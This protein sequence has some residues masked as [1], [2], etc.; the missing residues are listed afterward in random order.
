[1]GQDHKGRPMKKPACEQH[2]DVVRR[3][4]RKLAKYEIEESKRRNVPLWLRP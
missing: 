3:L 1:M 2:C 4:K